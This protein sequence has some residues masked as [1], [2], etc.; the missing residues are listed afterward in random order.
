MHERGELQGPVRV[1]SPDPG[2]S[3]GRVLHHHWRERGRRRE[4]RPNPSSRCYRGESS[5]RIALRVMRHFLPDP[6]PS[7]YPFIFRPYYHRGE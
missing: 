2:G 4:R 3:G 5:R 1:V 7:G 6:R